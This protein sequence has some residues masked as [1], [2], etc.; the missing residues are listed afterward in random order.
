MGRDGWT[1]R[2]PRRS[3]AGCRRSSMS[4]N[5]S[6]P[7]GFDLALHGQT[8]PGTTHATQGTRRRARGPG[9][10]DAVGTTAQGI[11]QLEPAAAGGGRGGV[12]RS[13]TRSA[14]RRSVRRSKKRNDE[15]QDRVLGDSA[16]GRW[17]IRGAHGSGAGHVCPAVRPSDPVLSMDEQPVQLLKETRVP[18]A[19]TKRAG[20][21][22]RVRAGRDREHFHVL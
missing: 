11:R 13:L 22:L 15:P 17:R 20:G 12:R 21:R 19:A 7:E 9:H 5:V 10:R 16:E 14:T 3:T 1:S 18:I 8:T 4:A 2:S 6:S